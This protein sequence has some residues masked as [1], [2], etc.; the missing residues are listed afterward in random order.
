M[1]A[2]LYTMNV[3]NVY[4]IFVSDRARVLIKAPTCQTILKYT[5]HVRLRKPSLMRATLE[6]ARFRSK[7][8]LNDRDP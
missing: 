2:L 8:F 6:V 1:M 5:I 3:E 7:R 4:P